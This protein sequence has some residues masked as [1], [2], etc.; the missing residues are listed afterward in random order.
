MTGWNLCHNSHKPARHRVNAAEGADV[1]KWRTDSG[2]SGKEA[3]PENARMRLAARYEVVQ[4]LNVRGKHYL[5]P[6]F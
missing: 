1:L 5:E 4:T 3:P 6:S 2:L